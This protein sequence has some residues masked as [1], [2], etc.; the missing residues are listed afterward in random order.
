MT[1]FM[2]F[3]IYQLGLTASEFKFVFYCLVSI[4]ILDYIQE[5]KDVYKL[6]AGR[7]IVFRFAVYITAILMIIYLGAYG[8][9]VS[10]NQFLYFQ[11]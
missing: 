3:R 5:K 6:L 10:D 1:R 9:D 2:Y 7:N 11:F 4:Y 8:E